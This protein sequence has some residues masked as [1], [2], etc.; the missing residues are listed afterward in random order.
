[1]E[2]H[3][4]IRQLVLSVLMLVFCY[5]SIYAQEQLVTLKLEN[6]TLREFFKAVERQTSYRFSYREEQ[7]DNR[8]DV[9]LDEES[10]PIGEVL[11]TVLSERNLTYSILSDKTIVISD[12]NASKP[13]ASQKI[14]GVVKDASGEAII[15]ANVML[16]GANVGAVTDIN[17]QFSF[18]APSDGVLVVSYIGYTSKEMPIRGKDFLSVE[19]S[20]D[21]QLIDEV[22]V[23]GYSKRTREKLI[24]SVSTMNTEG[25]VKSSV[26][27]LENALSG[28]VSGVF[29]RQTSGEPGKDDANLTIR[30]FG[31]AMVV[32]DG[33]PGRNFSDIDPEEIESISVL[34]DASA[35]AVY[36]MQGAN[37]V[38]L[39]TTKRGKK[40]AKTSVDINAKYSIQSAYNYPETA[41]T[42]LWQT[43]VN[44][45]N[46]NL[47]LINNRH[48]TITAE[49]ME[50]RQYGISTN[51]Y[52]E[53]V[54]NAPSTQANIKISGGSE[55]VSYFLL[56]AY[57]HQDGIWSTNSTSRDRFN[58]RANLDFEFWKDF[59]AS[60]N[61]GSI[62]NKAKYPGATSESIGRSLKYAAPNIPVRWETHPEYYAYGGEGTFNPMA[63][64]DPN[65]SGYQKEESN[66]TTIDLT[67]DYD[68]PFLE[69]LSVKGVL[70]YTLENS[71]NKDWLIDPVYMGYQEDS[72]EYY[73]NAAASN[74]DK[75]GLTLTDGKRT[76]LTMQGYLN[77]VQSF[78]EHSVNAGL[79][80]EAIEERYKTFFTSRGSFPS[81]VIDQLPAGNADRLLSNGETNRLYRT[82]S[83]IGR[84]SY[85]YASKYFFDFNFRYD[86]A[87]YFADK[88]GFFPSF[89]VGWMITKEN[90]MKPLR[91]VLNEL[92]I[93]AS[94]GKLGDLSAAKEYYTAN[95]QYYF[96]NGYK[97]PGSAITFG[98]RTIYTLDPTLNPNMA[99]TWASSQ[100]YNVGFDFKL[101]NGLLSGSMD[102]FY[103]KRTG[104][105]AQK[106]NDN[107]GALATWYNLD[108]DNT[109]GFEFSL[110]HQYKIKDF[111]YYISG[112]FSWARTKNG[113]VESISY[114]NGYSDWRNQLS[115]QWNNVRWG[116]KCIGRYESY[117][118]IDKAPI[119]MGT[120][121]NAE[122]LPGD[123]K[124]E[125]VN[126][127]GYIDEKDYRPIAR[128]AYPEIIYGLT[129]G[130]S[131]KNFDFTAFFQGGALCNF[132]ISSFDKNAFEEG[133]TYNNTWAYFADRWHKADYTDPNSSWIPGHFPAIRDMN[134]PNINRLPSDFWYFNG[135]YLR[136]KNIELGY[137]LPKKWLNKAKIENLRIFVSAT[138]L[139]TISSQ[140]YFDPE[141][142]ESFSTFA[143]YPQIRTYNIGASIKF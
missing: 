81:T 117:E 53:M 44:E 56:G 96:Q 108:S 32:V 20:E 99:F 54:Q 107:A 72:G 89:A 137:S 114:Q 2:K 78:K 126:K 14:S 24:S 87:Q 135:N 85:D 136:L 7:I 105:P 1:M 58:F 40:N 79:V 59:N 57:L 120:N 25:L 66:V 4:T 64:A 31:T 138:N 15:G 94:W 76:Q 45:Y 18:E 101:W 37:G 22:V 131:W 88:W 42:S 9:T 17:G 86:G 143:S 23:V 8:K 129:V 35:A 6:A 28:R 92:K 98:D 21:N 91:K 139:F 140:P 51:W 82:A 106:A 90:F 109:R 118:E 75:A 124:Y 123:L 36:G 34:K 30:G 39:V 26:P 71:W 128:T 46:A 50:Q 67:L 113:H 93:R 125:D 100:M 142:R 122:I 95:D 134:T 115:N 27:N 84:F 70:G 110:N 119:H 68:L 11:S 13:S 60:L 112:N 43:L 83:L 127:D 121:N 33:M 102:A 111:S 29:S 52:D 141:Q 80:F 61:I 103:R 12:K 73:L 3:L 104:L 48:A 16:K 10:A 55:K 49:E 47:K 65:A 62:F 19:L 63:L 132:E 97:Y 69:G 77:Y 74:T 5:G 130:A 116:L 133:K 38:I 41:N